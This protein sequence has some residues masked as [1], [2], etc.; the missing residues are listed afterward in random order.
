MLRLLRE[1]KVQE[2]KKIRTQRSAIHLPFLDFSMKKLARAHIAGANLSSTFLNGSNLSEADLEGDIS[3]FINTS[4]EQNSTSAKNQY[5]TNTFSTY[6]NSSYGIRV[7]YPSDWSIQ[8]SN[9][10]G[11]HIKV[12]TF[13]S[14][15]GPDSNPTGD[16]AIYRDKLYNSTTNLNNY[17]YG[18]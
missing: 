12:A 10:S 18:L 9:D 6:E 17:A 16:F 5:T 11:I 4:I 13:V 3:R 8:G 15:T 2:F 14:P 1:G 7:K